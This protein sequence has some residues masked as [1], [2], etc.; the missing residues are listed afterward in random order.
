YSPYHPI[1]WDICGRTPA[2]L[3]RTLAEIR[4][5]G[6]EAIAVP[7]DVS[8]D[9]QVQALIKKTV[10]AFGR[11]DVLVNNAGVRGSIRTIFC[12]KQ[13]D[14]ETKRPHQKNRRV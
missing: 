7:C 4:N 11:L 14:R 12:T 1:Y 3:E 8:Q 9:T 5:A 10:E 6:G 13:P 2:T